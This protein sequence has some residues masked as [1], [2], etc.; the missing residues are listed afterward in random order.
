MDV[1]ALVVRVLAIGTLAFTVQTE[2]ARLPA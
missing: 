2:I 1:A